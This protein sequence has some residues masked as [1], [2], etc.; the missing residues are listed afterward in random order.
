MMRT[1]KLAP[2]IPALN[3]EAALRCLLAEL[4]RTFT[5]WVIVVDNGSTDATAAVAQDAGAGLNNSFRV[6]ETAH[7][8]DTYAISAI[9]MVGF[10]VVLQK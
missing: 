9:R 3:E 10:T 4:P 2:V 6:P 5:Q 1:G 7:P 8:Q